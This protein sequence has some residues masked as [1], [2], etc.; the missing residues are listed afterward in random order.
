MAEIALDKKQIE[1]QAALSSIAKEIDS[2]Q[3]TGL[4][5]RF[6]NKTES[7][8][9]R[10]SLYIHGDVGRGKSMLMRKFFDEV[11]GKD[12]LYLHFNSFMRK[13]HENLKEIRA[14]K[15]HRDELIEALNRIVKNK[16][17]LC[18]DEFQVLDVAD[19]MLLSR[20]FSHLF[21]NGVT[22]IFTSN[23]HPLN[24][25]PNGL[26]REFFMEFVERVLL[27]N[28][29]IFHL[30]SITDYRLQYT[31]NLT[32]RYFVKDRY[33][34]KEIGEIIEHFREE[35]TEHPSKIKVWGRDL[36]INKTFETHSK[37]NNVNKKIAIISF[38]E[39]C[40]T[41]LA[42]S[43][44]NAI[45]RNFD[46]I[47]LL[48]VPQLTEDEANEARRFI[49]FIDEVYENQT[50]LIVLADSLPEKIYQ[51]GKGNDAFKR[52]ISRLNE[53]KSDHYWQNSKIL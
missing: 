26:Q 51:L 1:L 50:A 8:S 36:V 47:F 44:Y 43:D 11:K 52:T 21:R 40:R 38:D 5:G 16:K 34:V 4:L 17:L 14:E 37:E 45:C 25:Y 23:T 18:F 27:K 13:I 53:I 22:V 15:N 41:E 29:D 32:K 3:Q 42:A 28:C 30:D 10:K 12:K 6:F 46:L 33:S 39:I 24:L 7:S 49:L 48:N 20:I 2:K 31:K 35:S 19:A 9:S